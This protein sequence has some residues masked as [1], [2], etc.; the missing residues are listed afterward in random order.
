MRKSAS[1][2]LSPMM[3]RLPDYLGLFREFYP[4]SKQGSQ[5]KSE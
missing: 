1:Q 5:G 2:A 3:V 4:R